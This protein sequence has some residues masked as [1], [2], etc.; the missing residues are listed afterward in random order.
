MMGST[1]IE[2]KPQTFREWHAEPQRN[3][4]TPMQNAESGTFKSTQA[5]PIATAVERAKR[6]L[7]GR[8]SISS[9]FAI[10]IGINVYKDPAITNLEG[11]V[12]D[13][14]D[15]E[16]LLKE[17]YGV[18]GTRIV[19]LVNQ[20]ATR[21]KILG[22]LEKLVNHPEIGKND[23]IVIYYAGHGSEID[24][25]GGKIQMLL[26]QDFIK[27]GSSL[28]QGQGITDRRLCHLLTK[29]AKS[30][31]DN[32]TAIFDCCNSGSGTREIE[33]FGFSIRGL[34]L[35]STYTIPPDIF[36]QELVFKQP[37]RSSVS[38][39]TGYSSHILLAACKPSQKAK[40]NEDGGAF[41]SRLIALLRQRGLDRPSNADIIL[42]IEMP[43]L[44]DQSPQCEGMNKTRVL[45]DTTIGGH[46]GY[47]LQT[48]D[49]DP[50]E[51]IL[52]A[53]EAHGITINA[54]FAV[55]SDPGLT[56]FL[57]NAKAE[58]IKP[59]SSTLGAPSFPV[60]QRAYAL[61]TRYGQAQDLRL[62]VQ[63][64]KEFLGISKLL[65][66]EMGQSPNVSYRRSFF[67][68]G[69]PS[70]EEC[71]LALSLKNDGCIEFRIEN[72]FFRDH[73]PGLETMPVDNVSP[74]DSPYISSILR[75]A[76]DFYRN[77][78]HKSSTDDRS[79]KSFDV[80]CF[81]VTGRTTNDLTDIFEVAENATNLNVNG[82][83]EIN[84]DE[85]ALYGFQI[86][87]RSGVGVF[88]ALFYFDPRE[89]S[90]DEYYAPP[91]AAKGET[92]FCIPPK[93]HLTIGYGEY[94][95]SAFPWY[96]VPR[97]DATFDVGFLKLYIST[98]GDVDF[99]SIAQKTPF[100]TGAGRGCYQMLPKRK[101]LWHSKI[102]PIILQ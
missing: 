15:F 87:N 65:D 22:V 47:H 14:D 91:T 57:G 90:I 70:K 34:D 11:A 51:L 100:V 69:D 1:G 80:E 28:P 59:F 3:G 35:P 5:P 56:Q 53:G 71:D 27:G 37:L 25:S 97:G 18:P 38:E 95:S 84:F 26:P 42:Q 4:K 81:R 73:G 83:I 29:I 20:E 76:A 55:Y 99:Q 94:T 102:I 17:V 10:I 96:Y 16:L 64:C 78:R 46:R 43:D 82:K 23:P 30:K 101:Y 40:E 54:E 49:A 89:L 44:H 85:G 36:E 61:L 72:R 79:L 7:Y 33:P 13:A 6:S 93:G 12:K 45:F 41:T 77:F 2:G 67:S 88:A 31:S 98:E 63:L 8:P 86:H 24:M 75:S 32:I 92:D 58:A 68:V 21:E 66:E 48:S 9:L 39:T 74:D 52:E 19:K 60:P 50:A 62:H